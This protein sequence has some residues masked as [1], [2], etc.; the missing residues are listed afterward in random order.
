VKLTQQQEFV[1]GGYTLPEGSR[2]YFG[3]LFVGYQGRDGLLFAGKSRH[4]LLREGFGTS[5]RWPTEDQAANVPLREPAGGNA[6]ALAAG[7]HP[8]GHEAL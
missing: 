4:T 2:K 6:R 7:H 3:A 1:I 5:V 8:G